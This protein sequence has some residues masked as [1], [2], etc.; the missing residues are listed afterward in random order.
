MAVESVPVMTDWALELAENA[1][2]YV[3]LPPADERVVTDRYVL[4]RGRA[5]HPNFNSAQRFRLGADEVEDARAEIQAWFHERDRSACAWEIGSS[6]TPVD[7]AE[8]L[9]GLGLVEDDEPIQI[10]MAL[11]SPPS[12]PGPAGIDVRRAETPEERRLAAEIASKVFDTPLQ[13]QPPLPFPGTRF[14]SRTSTASR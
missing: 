12:E 14:I 4:W 1:N 8:R 10:G 13:G 2:T 7:L 3:P 9:L 11:T 6:A 5:D